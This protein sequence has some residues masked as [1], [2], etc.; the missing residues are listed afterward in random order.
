[1]SAFNQLYDTKSFSELDPKEDYRKI[2]KLADLDWEYQVK[3]LFYYDSHKDLVLCSQKVILIKTSDGEKEVAVRGKD[4][5]CT[6]A[7][8]LYKVFLNLKEELALSLYSIGHTREGKFI[9]IVCQMCSNEN[10]LPSKLGFK[11][12]LMIYATNDGNGKTKFAP[13]LIKDD[14]IEYQLSVLSNKEKNARGEVDYLH[15]CFELSHHYRFDSTEASFAVRESVDNHLQDFCDSLEQLRAIPIATHNVS[16]F[17]HAL[18]ARFNIGNEKTKRGYD[19]VMTELNENYDTFNKNDGGNGRTLLGLYLSFIYYIDVA[20]QRKMGLSGRIHSINFTHDNVTKRFA[21][22]E[23]L[24]IA[25][26]IIA[27]K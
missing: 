22:K 2:L 14:K 13:L 20:K 24:R 10:S 15:T 19:K 25:S 21:Y 16:E 18:Y 12:C 27:N 11:Q 1:M 23:L 5:K 17:H 26:Q 7:Q 4:F 8:E 6:S 9:Y 3:P